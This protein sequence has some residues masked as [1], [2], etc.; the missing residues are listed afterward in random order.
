MLKKYS[1]LLVLGVVLLFSSFSTGCKTVTLDP[2]GVYAGDK[3]L[4]TMDKSIVQSYH[5]IN[6]F[7]TWERD[8]RTSLAQWP[9]ITRTADFVRNNA[10]RWLKS[11]TNLRDA[12]AL[13]PTGENKSAFDLSIDVI[14]AA[15]AE[16]AK[17]QSQHTN[18]KPKTP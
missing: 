15:L 3:T 1:S 18:L 7:V 2:A 16:A 5:L 6:D 11:A 8:Y 12:Y 4:Y 14:S 13:N 10:K 9:E 17:Y